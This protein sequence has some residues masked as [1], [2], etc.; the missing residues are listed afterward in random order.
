MAHY[1][2]RNH[3]ERFTTLMDGYLPDWRARR[4]RLNASPLTAEAWGAQHT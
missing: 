3:G 4:D 1:F 2:E